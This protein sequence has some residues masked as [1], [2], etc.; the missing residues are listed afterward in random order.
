[1]TFLDEKFSNDKIL[2]QFFDCLKFGAVS[3]SPRPQRHCLIASDV[4]RDNAFRANSKA[5]NLRSRPRPRTYRKWKSK[6]KAKKT[7]DWENYRDNKCEN[8]TSYSRTI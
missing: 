4:F 3:P 8:S 6:V 2:R 1:L 7:W 5:I